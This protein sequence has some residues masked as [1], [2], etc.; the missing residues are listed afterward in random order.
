M[1]MSNHLVIETHGLSK[2]YKAIAALKS[3]DLRV[4][5]IFILGYS[6]FVELLPRVGDYLPWNLTSSLSAARPAMAMS[7]LL[8]QPLATWMPVAANLAGCIAFT[9]IAIWRFR[10]QEF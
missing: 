3:L 4:P 2:S 7:L 5:L 9:G 6:L 1:E 10:N 8:G